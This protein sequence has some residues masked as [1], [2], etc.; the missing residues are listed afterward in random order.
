MNHS[1][2][3]AADRLAKLRLGGGSKFRD[4]ARPRSSGRQPT[5]DLS[6]C[7]INRLRR[8]LD[9]AGPLEMRQSIRFNNRIYNRR[10]DTSSVP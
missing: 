8:P 10:T 3:T 5:T 9:I 1:A 2:C 7:M 6:V 4:S